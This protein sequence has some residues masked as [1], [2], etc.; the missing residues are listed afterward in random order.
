MAVNVRSSPSRIVV[1]GAGSHAKV[2]IEAIRAASLG[3]V[4]GLVDPSPAKNQL[5]G[6]PVLGGDESLPRL[7]AGRR[8]VA[9]FRCDGVFTKHVV[10]QLTRR[11]NRTLPEI[12]D[13]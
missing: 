6:V 12:Q 5:L 9:R 3:E 4:V 2:I 10:K 13:D 11:A 1:V 7:R 8:P